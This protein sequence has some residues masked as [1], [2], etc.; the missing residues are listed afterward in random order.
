MKTRNASGVEGVLL[1]PY[2]NEGKWVFRTYE[3]DGTF[4]DYDLN[5][6]DLSITIDDIDACLYEHDDGTNSLD[7]SPETL[8]IYWEFKMTNATYFS[9]SQAKKLAED[10]QS[11]HGE[12][13]RAETNKALDNIKAAA[14]KGMRTITFYSC[15]PIVVARLEKLDYT[16]SIVRDGRDGDFI[17]I[18]W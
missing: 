5:H 15:D 13:M 10:A 8:G 11:L 12:H 9:A 14:K 1:N 18:S 4:K 2:H 17:N 7:H 6:S 3:E 16:V